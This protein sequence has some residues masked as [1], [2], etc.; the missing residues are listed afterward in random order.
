MQVAKKASEFLNS[1]KLP[2]AIVL[3]VL[4]FQ[5]KSKEIVT[6]LLIRPLLSSITES[7]LIID[8]IIILLG[9]TTIIILI[10]KASKQVRLSPVFIT[11]TI[12]CCIVY[13]VFR[14]HFSRS[15][16][17]VHFDAKILSN[18]YL[19][20]ILLT[21]IIAIIIYYPIF[22]LV[23]K[24]IQKQL[25][26]RKIENIG[27]YVD[28]PTILNKNNDHQSRDPSIVDLKEKILITK[29]SKDAFS[30]GIIGKW[31]TGKT[32]FM[33]SLEEKLKIEK[34]H[35][36]QMKFNPWVSLSSENI[37]SIFFS[38]LSE[39]LSEYDDALKRQMLSYSKEL[40]QSAN[41]SFPLLNT[42]TNLSLVE[43]SVKEKFDHINDRIKN[44][45]KKIV[46]YIDDVDRLHNNEIIE[47]LRI[48]RNNANFD[49]TFFI[50]AYDKK[51]I[52]DAIRNC[53]I[54]NAETYLEKIFQ[55][56]YYLPLY[57]DKDFFKSYLLKELKKSLSE[58]DKNN[59]EELINYKRPTLYDTEFIPLIENYILSFRDINRFMNIFLLNYHKIKN[60]IYLPDYIAI[61]IIKLKY[62]EL[63]QSLYHGK[64]IYFL[65]QHPVSKTE[66]EQL[67]IQ[68]E[69]QTNSSKISSFVD[70]NY[71]ELAMDK[72]DITPALDLINAIFNTKTRTRTFKK[73]HLSITKPFC[74]ERYFDFIMDGRLDEKEFVEKIN[75][76]LNDL[77]KAI[78]SWNTSR[79]MASDLRIKFENFNEFD[80][81]DKFERVIKAIM[82]FADLP[83]LENP[84]Y[85]NSYD[86]ENLYKKLGG[87]NNPF[88]EI[89]QILYEEDGNRF[90]SF[91]KN[92]FD[93]SY[94]KWSFVHD[95]AVALI[96]NHSGYFIFDK[97]ELKTILK[98]NFLN[99]LNREDIVN[100][101]ILQF[102]NNLIRQFKKPN[103]GTND[104][105]EPID[106]GIEITRILKNKI[107]VDMVP[108]L[109]WCIR[110]NNPD[111]SY[112]FDNWTQVI[113]ETNDNF[114]LIISRISS[115][116][117][118]E[119]KRFYSKWK[120]SHN[121]P[122]IFEFQLLSPTID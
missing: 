13:L 14:S 83:I 56:E 107:L 106:D 120:A 68:T 18:L 60:N 63:Y 121:L 30:I 11:Y 117:I 102:Y 17:F 122:I 5:E 114:E 116:K 76:S 110:I 39:K 32:T 21:P 75:G 53:S 77:K 96:K 67:N 100:K 12:S 86:E 104:T 43:K 51:Y 59:L 45:R 71:K 24:R 38:E 7:N 36:I 64:Y 91:F 22:W 54:P 87:A 112:V 81:V 27:F 55:L 52:T 94:T 49:N 105:I 61:C 113:F 34:D 46:I 16:T 28:S 101:D 97:E 4:V 37:S 109:E 31:G 69:N 26:K 108:F 88:N 118:D 99:I 84:V 10:Y 40:L 111:G 90:K 78:N 42:I 29:S 98:E 33:N 2:I 70:E 62:P 6:S 15:F 58:N 57:N 9:L 50:V 19:L 80:S 23:S 89:I 79:E 65:P 115:E 72:K 20:D 41:S 44:L 8:T 25:A 103:L 35:I 95:F 48:I 66:V 47:V 82:Y 85:S 119:F 1:Y 92:L 93:E 3:F 73:K 74:F